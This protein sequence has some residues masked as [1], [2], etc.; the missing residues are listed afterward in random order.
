M[1][2]VIIILLKRGYKPFVLILEDGEVLRG[3]L[4]GI[5][6]GIGKM[7]FVLKFI[8]HDV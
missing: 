8:V 4:S 7:F 5:G 2:G 6:Y 1:L 3:L